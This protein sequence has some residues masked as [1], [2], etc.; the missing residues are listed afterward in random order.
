MQQKA[1]MMEQEVEASQPTIISLFQ[2]Y[3]NP[4]NATTEIIYQLATDGPV[5]L[6]IFN[7]LGE[8]VETVV[9]EEQTPGEKS[10][11]WDASG[12]SSGT[13][14]CKLTAGD[15]TQIRRMTLLR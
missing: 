12:F 4:F 8:K 15:L 14:F 3:P 5:K 9:D 10:V 6:E 11:I 1:K 2:N 7:L 13:Y